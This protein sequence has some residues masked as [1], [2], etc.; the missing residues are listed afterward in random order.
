MRLADR[1][2]RTWP[3][4]SAGMTLASG[5]HGKAEFTWEVKEDLAK[6]RAEQDRPKVGRKARRDGAAETPALAFPTS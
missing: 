4:V 5:S 6:V 3:V 2:P 1:S